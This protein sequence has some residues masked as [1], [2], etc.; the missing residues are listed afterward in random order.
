MRVR[1]ILFFPP[2]SFSVSSKA[3]NCVQHKGQM[4]TGMFLLIKHTSDQVL[5]TFTTQQHLAKQQQFD[6]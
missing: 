6:I 4:Q 1:S 3:P 5:P 2:Q